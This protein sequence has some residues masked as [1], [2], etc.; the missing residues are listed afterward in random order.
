MGNKAKKRKE[1]FDDINKIMQSKDKNRHHFMA[2]I[3]CLKT[4]QLEEIGSDELERVDIVDGQQRLTTLIILLKCIALYLEKSNEEINKKESRQINELQVK[5]N[6]RLILLQTN[7]V[8]RQIFREFLLKG[9]IPEAKSLNTSAEFN[10]CMA[11]N[12]CVKY[13]RSLSSYKNVIELLK[14][15][16]NKLEFI[17]YVLDDEGAVYT[18]FEVLNSRGLPVAWIDKCKSMLMGVTFE[19]NSTQVAQERMIELREQ[20]G[21]IYSVLG[22]KI[23]DEN[24]LLTIA[25]TLWDDENRSKKRLYSVEGAVDCFRAAVELNSEKVI[26]ISEWLLKVAESLVNKMSNVRLKAVTDIKHARLLAVAIDL[27]KHFSES[28]R[29]ILLR[30]WEHSSFKIFGLNR[31]DARTSI[32]D[33]T[34]LARDIIHQRCTFFDAKGR[35]QKLA[36]KVK[37]DDVVEKLRGESWFGSSY[38]IDLVY[39]LFKYEE[40]LARKKGQNISDIT[41]EKIWNEKFTKTVEHI[42]PKELNSVW[43]GKI[44]NSQEE[45]EPVVHNMGNLLLL[46][47]SENSQCAQKK[48]CDKKKIYSTVPLCTI[49]EIVECDDWSTKE[50]MEREDRILSFIKEEWKD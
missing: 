24:D 42:H 38:E 45:I 25:A 16:K 26:E 9:T 32:G 40:Y 39:I 3:V 15:I 46:P 29:E 43:K 19:K 10:L 44:G 18:V 34:C 20:W 35:M 17:F 41:W 2:T 49:A 6:G 30:E 1:L 33:Y 8:S 12:E 23:I 28:E 27:A 31:L 22:K 50:I 36:G 14:A 13:V 47:P 5:D 21:K 4:D 11:F 37:I 7:H 48:F